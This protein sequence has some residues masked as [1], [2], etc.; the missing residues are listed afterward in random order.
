[1][2]D[3]GSALMHHLCCCLVVLFCS[4]IRPSVRRSL[5][6]CDVASH[7]LAILIST[8]CLLRLWRDRFYVGGLWVDDGSLSFKDMLLVLMAIMMTYVC[9]PRSVWFIQRHTA[10]PSV[11]SFLTLFGVADGMHLLCDGLVHSQ[12]HGVW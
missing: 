9:A 7:A 11:S 12:W 6:R 2:P 3:V 1:M 4:Q 10:V 8:T 5:N